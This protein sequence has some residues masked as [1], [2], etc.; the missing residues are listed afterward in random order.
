M[1]IV[2][3]SLQKNF[4]VYINSRVKQ[5]QLGILFLQTRTLFETNL[6]EGLDTAFSLFRTPKS[7]FNQIGWFRQQS[8]VKLTPIIYSRQV[9]TAVADKYSF[10]FYWAGLINQKAICHSIQES[11]IMIF[12]PKTDVD[13]I[14]HYHYHY[15]Y[16]CFVHLVYIHSC[17]IY[18]FLLSPR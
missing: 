4:I 17:F 12:V 13:L 6:P 2:G 16:Y 18:T 11:I 14:S 15:W 3:S 1:F 7:D 10:I 9:Q 8:K 5:L